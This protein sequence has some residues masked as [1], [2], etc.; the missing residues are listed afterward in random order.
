MHPRPAPSALARPIGRCLVLLML[1]CF[2]FAAGAQQDPPTLAARLSAQQGTVSFSLAGDDSWYDAVPNRP[3]ASGDRLWTDRGTRAELHIGSTAVRLDE[4]TLLE[5]SELDD[6]AVRLT[7]RQGALQLRV[8]DDTAGERIEVDTANL[9]LVLQRPG[10]YRIGADPATGITQV[11]VD[12]GNAVVYGGNG[13]SQPLAAR[14]QLAV[15]GR[16]LQAAA[17]APLAGGEF[18]R[19]VAE[20]NLIEDQSVAARYVSRGVVG[21]QQLDAWGDWQ[22]DP[23]YGAVWFPREVD[24]GWAPYREGSWVDVAPWGWTWIDSAPWGFAPSHYGRWA[25]IGPRW[26]WV[27]G[28]RDA[29]PVYAPALVGF[30]G[31]TGAQAALALGDGRRGVGWF[32]LAPGEAWRPPYRASQRYIEQA[33]RMALYSQALALANTNGNLYVNQRRPDAVTVVPS[34]AFGRRALGRRDLVRLPVEALAG[35]PVAAAPPV[36][37]HFAPGIGGTAAFGF[38]GRAATALPPL[39]FRAR[40]PLQA[41]PQQAFGQAL[42]LQQAQQDQVV[43]QQQEALRRQQELQLREA[44]AQQQQQQW[45]QQRAAQAQQQ[46]AQAQQQMLVRQQQQRRAAQ[47]RAQAQQQAEAL[48]QQQQ[49]AAQLQ[50]QQQQ[51]L[52]RQQETLQ[53]AAAQQQ[54]RLQQ[55]QLQLQAQRQ[56]ELQMQQA[57]QQQLQQQAVLAQQ[58]QMLRLQDA[59][60]RAAQQQQ[61][62]QLQALQH[63]QEAQQRAAQQQQLQMQQA[64]QLQQQRAMQAQMLQ[65]QQAQLNALHQ[66]QQAAQARAA[67]AAQQMQARPH[68]LPGRPLYPGERAGNGP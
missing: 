46:A 32:P 13:V 48:R 22:N 62:Q 57:A 12:D 67:A 18:D 35:L 66:A 25:H 4:Q 14:Q 59:Q 44:Q 3:L 21:Y 37:P 11:A 10:Q 31:G 15:T 16:D 47:T 40:Q 55:Q 43:R 53:R 60:Q 9:A 56:Q 54:A 8:H 33:N 5:L 29:R 2:G 23:A 50:A 34:D 39:P 49:Q 51:E 42:R 63:M 64:A 45:L 20:R 36:P 52:L 26:G 24:A 1:L 41:D 7:L 27:P 65:A 19:W 30:V 38:A 58:Q 6:Q 61:Q 17:G 68:G 28:R